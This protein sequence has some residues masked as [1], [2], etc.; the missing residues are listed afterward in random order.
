M[1]VPRA[2]GLNEACWARGIYV[3]ELMGIIAVDS[4][5]EVLGS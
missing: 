2:Q 1:K 4:I 5:P 3:I